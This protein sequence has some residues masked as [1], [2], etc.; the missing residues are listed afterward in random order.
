MPDIENN[1]I[2]FIKTIIKYFDK[3]EDSVRHRLSQSPLLY[4]LVAGVAIVMFWRGVWQMIDAIPFL[5]YPTIS[6]IV[7]VCILL[8]TG[9][10]VSFFIGDQILISGLKH[11][12]RIAEKT[13]RDIA[14]E[15]SELA[16]VFGHL[17]MM[18]R[19]MREIKELIQNLQTKTSITKKAHK[20]PEELT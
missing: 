10:F 9:T 8:I 3:L 16:R 2:A 6:F 11:E 14:E 15:E 1:F 5:Q 13:E 18:E 20:K 12:K 19:D 7:S 4:A 17:H